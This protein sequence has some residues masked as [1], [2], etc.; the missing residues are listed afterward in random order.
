MAFPS[1]K[2]TYDSNT[3]SDFPSRTS[4][5]GVL[6]HR[7]TIQSYQGSISNSSVHTISP[8]TS[9]EGLLFS[10]SGQYRDSPIP[11]HKSSHSLEKLTFGLRNESSSTLCTIHEP[12]F[13]RSSI[14]T[15]TPE[16]ELP[17]LNM[18]NIPPPPIPG[19]APAAYPGA[20]KSVNAFAEETRN[21]PN[22]DDAVRSQATVA[23]NSAVVERPAPQP[24]TQEHGA[25]VA[26][27]AKATGAVPRRREKKED[28]ATDAD[29]IKRLQQICTD[30]DPSRLYRNLVKIGQG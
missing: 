16:Q 17:L 10:P 26:S 25:A 3:P 7:T 19:A 22:A 28:K 4:M 12:E 2:E 1:R 30:A 29:I 27:L 5:N 13:D 9:H 8:A 18:L 23:S 20:L 15:S 6:Y 21:F 24:H 14:E 11:D